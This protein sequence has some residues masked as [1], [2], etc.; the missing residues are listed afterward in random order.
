MER[1]G[2]TIYEEMIG[3]E[4]TES[5][6][7]ARLCNSE[8]VHEHV[9]EKERSLKIKPPTD[10]EISAAVSHVRPN[11][12][13]REN[14]TSTDGDRTRT[15]FKHEQDEVGTPKGLI[16]V[17]GNLSPEHFPEYAK[18]N[19]SKLNFPEK[20]SKCTLDRLTISSA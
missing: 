10:D 12:T 16:R 5:I 17:I 1:S 9:D 15:L 14:V 20:V 8:S 3:I 7:S 6:E 18:K 4:H 2:K 13:I 11:S 19:D